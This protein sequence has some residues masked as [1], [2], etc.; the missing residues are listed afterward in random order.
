MNPLLVQRLQLCFLLTALTCN[1][2]LKCTIFNN[3][4]ISPTGTVL[5]ITKHCWRLPHIQRKIN[6]WNKNILDR[7]LIKTDL[8]IFQTTATHRGTCGLELKNVFFISVFNQIDGQNFFHNKFY[9]MALHVS[10]TCAYHQEVKIAL[11]SLWYIYIYLFIY[12]YYFYIFIYLLHLGCHPVAVVILHVNKTWN[13]L[14]LDLSREG[15]MRS[16]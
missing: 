15:Y 5:F 12:L 1:R 9:F 8:F 7:N 6:N 3:L 14:L 13:W 4:T 11:H 16:M 10:S 2:A